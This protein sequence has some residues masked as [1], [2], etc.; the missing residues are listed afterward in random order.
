MRACVFPWQRS[1]SHRLAVVLAHFPGLLK[2]MNTVTLHLETDGVE[3]T[4]ELDANTLCPRSV[5][6]I[7]GRETILTKV[8]CTGENCLSS[9]KY[10]TFCECV[11]TLKLPESIHVYKACLFDQFEKLSV[12]INPNSLRS[13]G[14]RC[15]Q[16][17]NK[18]ESITFGENVKHLHEICFF[19]C[20]NLQTVD[21]SKTK[22]I[23]CQSI[24]IKCPALNIV[25][26]PATLNFLYYTFQNCEPHSVY[27]PSSIE[28]I[29]CFIYKSPSEPFTISG[30]TVV[31]IYLTD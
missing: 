13:V 2:I 30:K 4:R 14:P 29:H 3:Y 24:F 16:Y 12:L 26:F 8:Q 10:E 6:L 18:L 11:H 7:D 23:I 31:H 5:Q 22:L 27:I 20:E 28:N 21:L 25:R 1:Q 17:C 15:F 19:C 9:E